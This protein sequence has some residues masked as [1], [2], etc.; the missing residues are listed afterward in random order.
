MWMT[1][2]CAC[3]DIP[4]GG[5][6]GGVI[7]DPHSMSLNEQEQLC[8]GYVR[9]IVKNLG[10]NIDVPAPD[11]MT[12]GQHMLWMMDEYETIIQSIC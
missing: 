4:L 5:G 11:V 12:N 3:V 10:P 6:K 1:W 8:R 7:C 9:Q 2:K